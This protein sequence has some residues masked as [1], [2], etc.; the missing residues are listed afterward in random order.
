MIS[1]FEN[2]KHAFINGYATLKERYQGTLV[3]SFL[4]EAK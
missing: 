2:K 1:D 4:E 3:K